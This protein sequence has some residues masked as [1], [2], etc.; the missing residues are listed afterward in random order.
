MKIQSTSTPPVERKES[1]LN[2]QAK[3]KSIGA[4]GDTGADGANGISSIMINVEPSTTEKA[5][6]LTRELRVSEQFSQDFNIVNGVNTNIG[7]FSED[8]SIKR[9]ENTL[10]ALQ[11]ILEKIKKA[12]RMLKDEQTSRPEMKEMLLQNMVD[13]MMFEMHDIGEIVKEILRNPPDYTLSGR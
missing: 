10:T 3:P 11:L 5:N 9:N 2:P 8:A 13:L 6:Q 7:F 12:D 1:T 4:I